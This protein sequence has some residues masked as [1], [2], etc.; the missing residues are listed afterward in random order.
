MVALIG[1]IVENYIRYVSSNQ[2]RGTFIFRPPDTFLVSNTPFDYAQEPRVTI[3]EY[4][5][6]VMQR[7]GCTDKVLIIAL[8]Y[9]G[10]Y[11]S[12]MNQRYGSRG[13]FFAHTQQNSYL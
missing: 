10:K 6:Q 13:A 2:I 11:F 3:T 5:L 7:L 8:L 12:K 1:G 9:A 4:L